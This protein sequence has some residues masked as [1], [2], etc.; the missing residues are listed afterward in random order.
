MNNKLLKKIFKFRDD[1]NW[2]QFHNP[3]D[4]AISISLE[5]AELLE[6]F[7]WNNSKE[8]VENNYQEL[9]D[10]LADILI[11]CTLMADKLDIDLDEAVKKK[12][13]KNEKK[14]PV[15]KSYNSKEKYDQL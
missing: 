9:Q 4:L 13:E 2:S 14:Y 5:A 11:Y 10:E 6:L 8:T 7:Q 12:L 1:R 3:K 15:E